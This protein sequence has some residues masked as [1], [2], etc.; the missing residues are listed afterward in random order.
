MSKYGLTAAFV[1]IE[2]LHALLH[3]KVLFAIGQLYTVEDLER[4]RDYF[5]ADLLSVVTSYVLLLAS[6][7]ATTNQIVYLGFLAF[8][9]AALHSFYIYNWTMKNSFF[10][11]SIMEWS[12]EKSHINRIR[13]DGGYMFAYNTIGTIFDIYV[14][15]V[16]STTLYKVL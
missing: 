16:F 15:Y 7:N 1:A 2:A 14:H 9:H 8:A 5:V 12:A 6:N 4:K 3:I 13:N 11:R 10:I